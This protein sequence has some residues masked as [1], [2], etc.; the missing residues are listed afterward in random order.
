MPNRLFS[1]RELLRQ[2][3]LAGGLAALGGV[4]TEGAARAARSA[5]E[6]LDVACIGVGGQGARDLSE[7]AAHPRVNIVALCDVDDA[8]AAESYNKFPDAKKYHD[9]RRLLDRE[10]R[11]LD[12]VVVST[13]D[14]THAIAAVS[15]M[16]LNKH[17]YCQ[18]PLTRTVG[19]ARLLME[20]ARRH[21][22]V[23]QMGTQGHPSY[24]PTVELIRSG[25]IGP[26][27]E[28]HVCTDRPI[29]PQ[30]MDRRPAGTPP[31][32]ATLHW[33]QWLGPAP[34]RPYHP[35]YLPFK[36]R[37]WWDF[38]T[39]ALGDMACHLM[40]GAFW[41]L[42]LKY[43]DTVEAQGEALKPESAPKWSI[44]RYT[45]P[46]RGA[47]PPV[48][49]VWYDGG[50]KPPP[51]VLDGLTLPADFNGSL[52]LGDKG[53]LLAEHGGKPRLLP[54]ER[55]KDYPAPA[56]FLPRSPGHYREWVEACLGGGPTAS[57]FDYAAPMT[58]SVLLGNVAFRVGKKLEWDATTLKAKNCPEADQYVWQ[59]ARRGWTL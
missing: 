1:R 24:A 35:D 7:V 45:F 19:E 39:G 34:E 23:T 56:P 21:R 6:K 40:D 47:Q 44:V 15:A 25:A 50:K 52:F 46:R 38:G 37:G 29:W 14:H 30:G 27:R 54:E 5:N 9:L 31:V 8:S 53:R 57:N 4:W 32:P 33:E 41:A 12:A 36:W 11:N 10:A 3:T 20:T 49:L 22:V 2:A 42:D 55:F 26:V 28:V 17:V 16:R 51:E 18:K 48:T 13:P 58:E 59:P 43:P